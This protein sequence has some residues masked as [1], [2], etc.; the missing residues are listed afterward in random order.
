MS[1]TETQSITPDYLGREM[2]LAASSAQPSPKFNS[3]RWQT[4]Y[5]SDYQAHTL[6]D[7]RAAPPSADLKMGAQLSSK[8]LHFQGSSTYRNDFVF[9][10]ADLYRSQNLRAKVPHNR[11]TDLMSGIHLGSDDFEEEPVKPRLQKPAW[12]QPSWERPAAG[13]RGP[14]PV[15][16][17]GVAFWVDHE[18]PPTPLAQT[19]DA[20]RVQ[21]LSN[22]ELQDP[23]TMRVGRSGEGAAP[24]RPRLG[25]CPGDDDGEAR[26]RVD[27]ASLPWRGGQ[28][29]RREEEGGPLDV[30]A[31]GRR[32]HALQMGL[33]LSRA[34]AAHMETCGMATWASLAFRKLQDT[35]SAM[36]DL[37]VA[38]RSWA[39]RPADLL[40]KLEETIT[41]LE[42][43][44]N[45]LREVLV[46]DLGHQHPPQELQAEVEFIGAMLQEALRWAR[47]VKGER[48]HLARQSVPSKTASRWT[49]SVEKARS[50]GPAP[51][52]EGSREVTP[53]ASP[54]ARGGLHATGARP[55]DP[56]TP[57]SATG[58][59]LAAAK[60]QPEHRH[61]SE[62]T[63]VYET[64]MELRV[65]RWGERDGTEDEKVYQQ[66]PQ[67]LEVLED[68]GEL[69]TAR[70]GQVMVGLWEV[71]RHLQACL[72]AVQQTRAL[73]PKDGPGAG[74]APEKHLQQGIDAVLAV[75]E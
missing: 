46:R 20:Y 75:L 17:P 31:A 6:T 24:S 55:S 18:C 16:L 38:S 50:P 27:D 37:E 15:K 49:D 73:Q 71:V 59:F 45:C 72:R 60:E 47:A 8:H 26:S 2:K 5:T 43:S 33:Q 21:P 56:A 44:I 48:S 29:G 39:R 58:D 36:T 64:Q 74:R 23:G 10:D 61:V 62:A 13:K 68:G 63:N 32:T 70:R 40:P 66:E 52:S 12:E 9:H 3:K 51:R 30:S 69:G 25:G 65:E 35:V 28:H 4:T 54:R 14:A 1:V 67:D 19:R 53:T 41:Q 11:Q 57:R 42:E 7:L 34:A 22:A